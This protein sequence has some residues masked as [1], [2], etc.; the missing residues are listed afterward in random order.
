MIIDSNNNSVIAD[1]KCVLIGDI[2]TNNIKIYKENSFLRFATDYDINI[3][4]RDEIKMLNILLD[5]K[6]ERKEK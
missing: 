6:R 1:D 2:E 5:C 4:Y 3:T